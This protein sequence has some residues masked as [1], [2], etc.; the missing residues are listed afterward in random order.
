[1]GWSVV[2][3]TGLTYH[4][5][6][7]SV[8]GFTIVSPLAGDSSFLFDM[9]GQIVHR[10]RY[11]GVTPQ[12][13]Q[14]LPGG[15]LLMIGKELRFGRP[16]SDAPIDPPPTLKEHVRR[17]GGDASII[18]EYD[19]DGNL[20]W[21]YKNELIHHDLVRLENGNTM[22][23]EYVG[24][25][26][27]VARQVKG[28]YKKPREK[29]PP[30]VG[31]DIVEIDPAGNEI[32]RISTWKM[33]DPKK[34]RICPLER[35]WEWTHGNAF[36]LMP[37]GKIVFSAREISLVIIIDPLTE[38]IT[39]RYGYPDL[40]HQHDV[41]VLRNGNIQIFDNGMHSQHLPWSRVLE[42]N[43]DTSEIVWKFEMDPPE[44][45]YSPLIS[46]AHRLPRDNVLICEGMTGRLLE[47]TR[48]GEPA[49]EWINP[50][51][52]QHCPGVNMSWVYRAY[53]YEPDYP[54][55]AGRELNPDNHLE[56]NRAHGLM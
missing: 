22:F 43:P 27:D 48:R 54:G 35:R 26:P 17:L 9:D 30:L 21:E 8:K 40:A 53:R 49:W 37:D 23:L 3:K 44:A 11:E 16:P 38:E 51:V 2:R 32:S 28:G 55:L 39:W 18:Q 14:L 56:L 34:D 10:W 42:V 41:S 20:V 46:G 24:I 45:M 1:M 29:L 5:P 12:Y 15:N 31:D 4:R 47:V 50:F 33:L 13:A 6:Q 36:D 25:P 52:N 7:L 19:W